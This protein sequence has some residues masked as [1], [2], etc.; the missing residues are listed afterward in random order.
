M[1]RIPYQQK[2]NS[3]LKKKKKKN[4]LKRKKTH[5]KK[6][7]NGMW[8]SQQKKDDKCFQRCLGGPH[9]FPCLKGLPHGDSQSPS[10]SRNLNSAPASV[11]FF[12]YKVPQNLL[13]LAASEMSLPQWRASCFLFPKNHVPKDSIHY[14]SKNNGTC[15]FSFCLFPKITWAKNVLKNKRQLQKLLL[16]KGGMFKGFMALT[17]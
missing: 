8:G 11:C 12:V 2:V 14:I 16:L 6:N 1:G 15:N 3:I 5:L 10:T 9:C 4:Y 13:H 17:V 7:R